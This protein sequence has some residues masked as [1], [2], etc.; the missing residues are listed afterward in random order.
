MIE[1]QYR[2]KTIRHGG[3]ICGQSN[4]FPILS[5]R[6]REKGR[7]K[8]NR[9]KDAEI[10]QFACNRFMSTYYKNSKGL[11]RAIRNEDYRYDYVR[12]MLFM[13]ILTSEFGGSMD[14][15]VKSIVR[16]EFVMNK[17]DLEERKDIDDIAKSIVTNGWKTTDMQ[18]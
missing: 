4:L 2:V 18:I 7:I 9:I 15:F 12:I 1:I 14:E 3:L 5:I 6:Y 10:D 8:W 16:E 17:A 13:E 11:V